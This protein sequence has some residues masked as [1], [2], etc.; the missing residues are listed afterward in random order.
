MLTK[1]FSLLSLSALALTFSA[2]SS[3]T[4]L[5]G[6]DESLTGGQKWLFSAKEASNG[7]TDTISIYLTKSGEKM[8]LGD[9]TITPIQ[10][11]G[12]LEKTIDN[13]LV[14]VQC[15]SADTGGLSATDSCI[16]YINGKQAAKL[17]L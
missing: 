2:C 17:Y 13:K 11:A 15:R 6:A 8:A 12:I 14:S 16:V 7:I 1:L 10:P 4:P 5:V 3:I 9:M